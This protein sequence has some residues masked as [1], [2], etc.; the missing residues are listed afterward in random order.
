M[1]AT[2]AAMHLV[3]LLLAV[4][5]L[6]RT[7]IPLLRNMNHPAGPIAVALIDI[8]PQIAG[9]FGAVATKMDLADALLM[10]AVAGVAAVRGVM[11]TDAA[12]T[13]V[14]GVLAFTSLQACGMFDANPQS[15]AD[16]LIEAHERGCPAYE[17]ACKA[18][19]RACSQVA[20]TL[21][22]F[23][24]VRVGED[25]VMAGGAAGQ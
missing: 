10:A 14:L 19:P 25:D 2:E 5:R 3:A 15:A 9:Y 7:A 20:D 6:G 12:K 13:V 23:R 21:C 22:Q 17:F 8:S 11:A 24:V 4:A 16:A 1:S 18:D